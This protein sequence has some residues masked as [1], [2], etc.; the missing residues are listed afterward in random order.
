MPTC[1]DVAR[2]RRLVRQHATDAARPSPR[3]RAGDDPAT[4]EIAGRE[5]PDMFKA[6]EGRWGSREVE[7][8][9]VELVGADGQR[10]ARV[11]VGRAA[12]DSA[13]GARAPA[14]SSDFVFG[15]G[16]FNAEG[17]CC[18][19]TNTQSK[20]RRPA[21]LIGDGEVAVRHRQPRSRRRHLQARRRGAPRERRAVRLPPPALHVSRDV[22]AEGSGHLPA[23][24]PL[25]VLRRRSRSGL[26]GSA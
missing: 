16:I 19:G 12:G 23:A 20:A 2:G 14:A 1:S 7:I 3:D 9:G 11:P 26:D 18:Y 25:D 4:V 15:V 22:A 5:P 21:R 6:A 10:G 13:A 17:V 8:V 24:A